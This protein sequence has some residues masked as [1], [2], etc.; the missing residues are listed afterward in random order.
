M[1]D[2]IVEYGVDI[3]S[4]WSFVDG[5][6]KLVSSK[7]NLIQAILNRLNTLQDSLNLFYGDYGSYLQSYFGWR[8][9]EQ[10]LE[11]IRV[12]IQTV[13]VKDPRLSSF[14]V[15]TE[16]DDDGN[17]RVILDVSF[18]EDDDFTVNLVLTGNGIING[19]V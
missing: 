5:D 3:N 15:V 2:T 6:L 1:S 14:S 9:N 18:N 8:R 19:E 16:F 10:T 7:D 4:E 17:V 11:F 13:L 12:E